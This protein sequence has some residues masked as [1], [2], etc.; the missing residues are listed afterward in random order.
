MARDLAVEGAWY[1]Y[2]QYV[3]LYYGFDFGL[4]WSLNLGVTF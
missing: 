3:E 4:A 1:N 2:G